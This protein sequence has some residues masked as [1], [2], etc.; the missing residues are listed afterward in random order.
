MAGLAQ[1]HAVRQIGRP[2]VSTPP[3]DVMRLRHLGRKPA[4]RASA[5]AFDEGQ[6][7]SFREEPSLA[8]PVEDLTVT[9]EHTGNHPAA[10]RHPARGTD[11][12]LLTDT[13]DLGRSAPGLQVVEGHPH[14]DGG[15]GQRHTLIPTSENV[16][17]EQCQRVGL[18]HRHAA[19]ISIGRFSRRLVLARREGGRDV[20]ADRRH[21]RSGSLGVESPVEMHHA[22]TLEDRQR[23]PRPS[24]LVARRA[25]VGVEPPLRPIDDLAHVIERQVDGRVDEGLL[26]FGDLLRADRDPAPLEKREDQRR[27]LHAEPPGEQ[28]RAYERIPSRQRRSEQI[29]ARR[30][31]LADSDQSRCLSER[32]AGRR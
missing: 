29:S 19:T 23:P 31:G 30:R 12:D 32:D 25:A 7:L 16:R 20:P 2:R 8:A 3:P 4:H 1:Q 10:R 9:A 15:A 14:D 5:V 11:A 26:G 24:L 6:S 22:V 27:S 28:S 18:K 13:V 17:A 21:D